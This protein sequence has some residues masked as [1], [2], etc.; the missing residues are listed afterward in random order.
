M[1]LIFPQS[2]QKGKRKSLDLPAKAVL[3]PEEIRDGGIITQRGLSYS[4]G[5]E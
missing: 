3:K 5:V 1:I 2:H 4:K